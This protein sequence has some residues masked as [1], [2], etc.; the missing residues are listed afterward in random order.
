MMK[1]LVA[2]ALAFAGLIVHA[3]FAVT[4]VRGSGKTVYGLSVSFDATD[5]DR[6]LFCA[7]GATDGGDDLNAW[8]DFFRVSVPAGATS[9]EVACPAPIDMTSSKVRFFFAPTTVTACDALLEFVEATGTQYIDT[10][11]YASGPKTATHA[12]FA[13]PA[14]S[15]TDQILF[16]ARSDDSD[17]L[18]F[19]FSFQV[20]SGNQF[21]FNC[22]DLIHNTGSG[23][24]PTAGAIYTVTLDSPNRLAL[25]QDNAGA[26]VYRY[27]IPSEWPHVRTA[28]RTMLAFADHGY[29]TPCGFAS[30]RLYALDI[31]EDGEKVRDYKPAVCGG[32]VGLYDAVE[33]TFSPSASET[34]FLGGAKVANATITGA[35]SASETL[36]D[37]ADDAAVGTPAVADG[38]GN[39]QMTISFTFDGYGYGSTS[40]T[41]VKLL[42]STDPTLAGATEVTVASGVSAALPNTVSTTLTGLPQKTGYFAKIVVTGSN[43]VTAEYPFAFTV[44]SNADT[45]IWT[46]AAGGDWENPENWQQNGAA[47]TECPGAYD[48]VNFD[49]AN[50]ACAKGTYTIRLNGDV[51]I[52]TLYF[53]PKDLSEPTTVTV[54]LQG[55]ALHATTEI[56]ARSTTTFERRTILRFLDGTV[57]CDTAKKGWNVEG[58]FCVDRQSNSNS[59]TGHMI[60]DN[61]RAKFEGNFEVCGKF[62]SLVMTNGAWAVGGTS[63]YSNNNGGF[64]HITGEGTVV[65]GETTALIV[66]GSQNHGLVGTTLVD[67]VAYV[68]SKHLEV[69][70]GTLGTRLIVDNAEI[71]AHTGNTYGWHMVG[72]MSSNLTNGNAQ[73]IVRNGGKVTTKVKDLYVGMTN[74]GDSDNGKRMTTNNQVHVESGGVLEAVRIQVGRQWSWNNRIFVENG[75][76]NTSGILLGSYSPVKIGD[77][78]YAGTSS[79][80]WLFVSG[81]NSCITLTGTGNN[82]ADTSPLSLRY[83]AGLHFDIPAAGYVDTPVKGPNGNCYATKATIPGCADLPS[84]LEIAADAFA[85]AQPET[86][87]A[88]MTFGKDSSAAYG[89]L[90]DNFTYLGKERYKGTLSVSDDGK[91]L[92]YTTPKAQGLMLLLR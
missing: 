62:G 86:T 21:A 71:C 78:S 59:E 67:R 68:Y 84:R 47:A 44:R 73:L 49:N 85:R 26:D 3:E 87:V 88:L 22:K 9:A 15:K 36:T 57:T 35:T 23:K 45:F 65:T 79:N 18:A 69:S 28:T 2:V 5:E 17:T 50:A 12:R 31:C 48:T 41:T 27:T 81:T 77:V 51:N 32:A 70:P 46:N 82:N 76:I 92:F 38:A 19:H 40:A 20:N 10:G 72:Y 39:G 4:S 42:Y 14:E 61:V 64:M 13:Y 1:K 34:A 43:G 80:N 58:G 8:D 52:K 66:G 33:K 83:Q 37:F 63:L 30:A 91:T 53:Y 16:G 25:V 54:D 89:E 60:L 74:S 55:H 75:T 24:K 6:L 29:G 11:V 56:N 90:M 7:S